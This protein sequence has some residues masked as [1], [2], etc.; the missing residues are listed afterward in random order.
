[1]ED[2]SKTLAPCY[3]ESVENDGHGNAPGAGCRQHLGFTKGMAIAFVN[4]NGLRSHLD[5]VKI[6]MIDLG[7]LALNETKLSLDYS[8]DLTSV[9]GFQQE[10]LDRTCHGGGVSMYVKDSINYKPRPGVPSD[11]LETICIEVEPPKSKSFL[12]LTWYRPPSSPVSS[13]DKLE[14]MLS[15]L[16]KE[17]KEIT[18][19]GDTNL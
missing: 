7:I 18:L 12:V 3:I 17:G 9:A 15:Y 2:A 16:D 6:L 14:K 5:E 8:K 1:M 19:L 13:F 10:G 4:V 11:D